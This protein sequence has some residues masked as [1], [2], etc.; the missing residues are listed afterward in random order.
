MHVDLQTKD[1]RPGLKQICQPHQLNVSGVRAMEKLMP[2][3][4][5][6]VGGGGGGVAWGHSRI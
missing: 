4:Y 5:Q 2:G 1:R 3:F 6:E